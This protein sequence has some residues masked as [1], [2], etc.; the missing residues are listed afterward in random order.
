[1]GQKVGQYEYGVVFIL[2]NADFNRF[3]AR[4]A[5]YTVKGKRNRRPLIFFDT[6]VIVRLEKCKV[7]VLIK[8]SRL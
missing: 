2:T 5:N 8:R 3:A 7:V 4:F 1:M 6:A